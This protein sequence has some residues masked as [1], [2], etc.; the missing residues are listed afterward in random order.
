MKKIIIEFLKFSKRNIFILF[1]FVAINMY[2]ATIPAQILGTIIDL[3]GQI[4]ENKIE[5]FH[6]IF[7]LLGIS[8][9][10]LLSRLILK[11]LDIL[12]PRTLE[13]MIR[14]HLFSH[15]LNMDVSMIQTIK[16]GEIMSHFVK[17]I[18]EMRFAC[19]HLFSFGSRILFTFLFAI[20]AMSTQVNLKLTIL[21]LLPLLVAMILLSFLRLFVQKKYQQAQEDFT[22]LSEFIQE[23]TDAIRTT[24][25]YQL[26]DQQIEIFKRK[27]NQVKNSQLKSDFLLIL[28][29]VLMHLG[30]GLSYGISILFGSKMI[31][32]GTITLG[33]F[34]AFHS[35]IALFVNPVAW[36]PRI[37]GR[38]KKGQV[39]YR[40]L[41]KML[42]LEEER[43]IERLPSSITNLQGDIEIK[44]LSFY[45]KGFMEPALSH[46]NMTIKQGQTIGIIG[47]VGSG[48]STLMNLLVKLYE[49]PEGKIV[50]GG[51]DINELSIPM[52]REN[53]C[54]ITQ[55]NFLFSTTIKQNISLFRDG[56]EEDEIKNSLENAMIYNEVMTLPNGMDTIIGERGVDLSGGQKQRIVISRAFL[57]RSNF[58][59]FDDT[60]SALDNKTEEQLLKNIKKL[61]KG[62]TCMIISNRISDIKHADQIFV[63]ENGS[64]KEQG[65]HKE[66][67][68]NKQQYYEF[69]KQ[70]A[71][72]N[73]DSILS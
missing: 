6:L 16:N 17:D 11:Y 50:I 41:D 5:I 10:L 48:K 7:K 13:R 46:I 19:H 60:F 34:I 73:E 27:N 14:D 67:L 35:Y 21:S 42:K 28:L 37:V 62:K 72:Y 31:Q 12:I 29:S 32:N 20:H 23:S 68:A 18:S 45:Y 36:F 53:I 33:D 69:Y 54:Y 25:A 70:Q 9:L 26:E 47:Q 39:S 57:N 59:I 24:K 8:V 61:T 43:K 22:K 1:L 66:L 51:K 4:E 2:L 71:S 52:L 40:R 63:L 55:E 38:L 3:L 56:Y 15:F 64:I 49:V 58:I 30:F 44:D 65:T